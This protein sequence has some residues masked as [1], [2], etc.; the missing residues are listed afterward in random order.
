MA[1][2]T[3]RRFLATAAAGLSGGLAG[4]DESTADE[5]TETPGVDGLP[6]IERDPEYETL[7]GPEDRP[8]YWLAPEAETERSETTPTRVRGRNLIASAET[9]ERVRFADGF[10]ADAAQEFITA[11]D[12]ENETLYLSPRRA[13]ACFEIR[14]CYV[15]WAVDEIHTQYGS[16][17]RDADVRCEADTREMVVSVI[18]IPDA[19]DPD[20]VRS[21]G[22]GWSSEGC[23]PPRRDRTERTETSPRGV[24]PITDAG[25]TPGGNASEGGARQ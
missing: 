16:Y 24:G 14:P 17:Y 13:K 2:S 18:R 8:V 1:P 19:L 23:R 3:R 20:Q 10:D 25:E 12:F 22:G 15:E 6:N 7:R 11:T 5:R 21:Y 4:C 9:A